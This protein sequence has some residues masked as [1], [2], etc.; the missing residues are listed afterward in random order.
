MTRL[1]IIAVLAAFIA[2]WLA[3]KRARLG[4]TYQATAGGL[5]SVAAS[6]GRYGVAKVLRLSPGVVHVRVCQGRSDARPASVEP[7]RLQLGRFGDP[8]P[9]VGHLPVSPRV[10]ASWKPQL[11]AVVEA[12]ESELD[13]YHEWKSAEGGIWD[14][15]LSL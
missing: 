8:E 6:G 14:Q 11:L 13:G 1:L 7:A 4:P 2:G 10:F 12:A 5:Y 9:G 3:F 15:G